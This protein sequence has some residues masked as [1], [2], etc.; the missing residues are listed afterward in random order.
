M[1]EAVIA[2]EGT[3]NELYESPADLFVADFIGD[4]NVVEVEIVSIADAT[5]QVRLGASVFSLARRGC[6]VGPSHVAIRPE[7]FRLSTAMDGEGLTGTVRKATYLG[8]HM[9]YRVESEIGELFVVD[10]RIESP[11]RAGV[12]VSIE[13]ADHGVTLIKE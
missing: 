10:S 3:P 12:T 4:A 13:L 2:Q 6:S 5:A 11:I 8:N 9:E 1:N 7:A